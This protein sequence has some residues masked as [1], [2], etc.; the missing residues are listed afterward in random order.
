MGSESLLSQVYGELWGLWTALDGVVR[1]CGPQ[2]SFE[3]IW[4]VWKSSG[5]F[6]WALEGY[7]GLWSALGGSRELWKTLDGFE[8]L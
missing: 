7:A 2:D 6:K 8:G 1:L 3:L 4:M 5:E